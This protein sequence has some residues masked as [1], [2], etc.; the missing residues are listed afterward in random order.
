[1]LESASVELFPSPLPF[2]AGAGAGAEACSTDCTAEEDA[3]WR[4]SRRPPPLN[5]WDEP[6]QLGMTGLGA[7]IGALPREEGS[8]AGAVEASSEVTLG[9]E[10]RVAEVVA[11][12]DVPASLVAP[13]DVEE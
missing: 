1:M 13:L 12:S 6:A 5:S 7:A 2:A 3:G 9:C 4:V 11:A 10:E 8:D